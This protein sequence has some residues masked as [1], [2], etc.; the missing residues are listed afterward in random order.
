[1]QAK[2][3]FI[4]LLKELTNNAKAPK[5]PDLF[6]LMVPNSLYSVDCF[7]CPKFNVPDDGL[8]LI[9]QQR[10]PLGIIIFYLLGSPFFIAHSVIVYM[11]APEAARNNMNMF[12]FLTLA[13]FFL[14][15][16]WLLILSIYYF[17]FAKFYLVFTP[18]E[19]RA[20][21]GLRWKNPAWRLTRTDICTIKL[22]EKLAGSSGKG[23]ASEDKY[24]WVMDVICNDQ[25]KFALSLFSYEGIKKE[26]WAWLGELTALWAN[27]TFLSDEPKK[28]TLHDR[29]R[30]AVKKREEELK[31]KGK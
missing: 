24:K 16:I 6:R 4:F 5:P 20:H 3:D 2:Q 18:N 10:Y 21:R 19:L 30:E 29:F 23:A 9:I 7:K 22:Y 31:E 15:G 25:T 28:T 14:C 1:M 8:S 26:D 27:A 11:Y 13:F 12:A 17:A